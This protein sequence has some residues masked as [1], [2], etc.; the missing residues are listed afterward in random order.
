MKT[1]LKKSPYWAVIAVYMLITFEFF[2]MASPFALY[3]YSL[4]RPGLTFLEKIPAI[5]WIT[6]FFL[7]H[8]VET[9]TSALFN[10]VK[11]TGIIMSGLGLLVFI[12]CASQVYYAKLFKKGV[13]T[14]GIYKIIR[15]PQYSAFA[16][17]SL[18]LLLLWPRYLSL[19]M[20]VTVLFIYYFLAKAEE[21]ECEK[22]FEESYIKYKNQ[23]YMFVPL[24]RINFT[25]LKKLRSPY[26]VSIILILYF[27][28]LSGSVR[29]AHLI[30]KQSIRS[31]YLQYKENVTYVSIYEIDE[32][33]LQ[34]I[35]TLVT[36]SEEFDKIV[37]KNSNLI[38][39]IVPTDFY[40]SEIPMLAPENAPCHVFNPDHEIADYKV[41]LTE[42]R[43]KTKPDKK[44]PDVLFT[45]RSLQPLS[46]IW[47]DMRNLAIRRT[48]LL[49]EKAIRYKN[50]A[51][52]VF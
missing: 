18:G 3:F 37:S 40:I 49:T 16:V 48:T 5:A 28:C 2:Y 14:G 52:P 45:S 6:G 27:L 23:T 21:K 24:V 26:R 13:V 29:F 47:L 30:K 25:P 35:I 12:I 10:S 19:F 38:A 42:G 9:T 32:S 46:E 11:T 1:T 36:A 50:I 7:P 4:Y 43:P 51:E 31:L 17:C 15:H 20:F 22:K 33:E 39:Y 41:I 8:L 44:N 34:K